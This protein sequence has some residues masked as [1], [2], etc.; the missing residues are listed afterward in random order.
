M[1][2]LRFSV[3]AD[4]FQWTPTIIDGVPTHTL[5]PLALVH[6]RAGAAA[7]GAFG[8]SRP[9]TD[10]TRQARLIDVFLSD[11]DPR[12]REPTVTPTTDVQ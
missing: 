1:D 9:H 8:P 5:S 7:T 12:E 2:Q 6:I 4:L 10:A 11:L 3:P